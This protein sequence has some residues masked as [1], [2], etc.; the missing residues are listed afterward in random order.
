MRMS[1]HLRF[2]GHLTFELMVELEVERQASFELSST[3][4]CLA[5]CWSPW[6]VDHRPWFCSALGMLHQQTR[7]AFG[8]WFGRNSHQD[9]RFWSPSLVWP[10]LVVCSHNHQFSGRKYG[11]LWLWYW[12][13]CNWIS[14][15]SSYRPTATCNL[16]EFCLWQSSIWSNWSTLISTP[17]LHKPANLHD[18]PFW[19]V[20]YVQSDQDT[21]RK[22]WIEK[23]MLKW[24]GICTYFLCRWCIDSLDLLFRA[25]GHWLHWSGD[26][27]SHHMV[28]LSISEPRSASAPRLHSRD[29]IG[30]KQLWA[31]AF[32][33][34]RN[35]SSKP[36]E[37]LN[38]LHWFA[39]E[40]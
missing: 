23:N 8:L 30:L 14:T 36:W 10:A 22:L 20:R 11:L 12:C 28:L 6:A 27:H 9:T 35:T 17:W 33:N 5:L 29:R 19:R 34:L 21:P 15:W 31:G 38:F 26:C 4:V 18:I 13:R 2:C 1:S 40:I 16:V 32:S 7:S 39:S 25:S 37:Y 24:I 3:L